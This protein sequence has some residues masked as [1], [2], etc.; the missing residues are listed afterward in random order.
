MD[1]QQFISSTTKYSK[2]ITEINSM[3]R[4]VTI[5]NKLTIEQKQKEF[6]ILKKDIERL[7]LQLIELSKKDL[8]M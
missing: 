4:R 8:Q 5:N 3:I 2:Q 7:S 1:V 6:Y